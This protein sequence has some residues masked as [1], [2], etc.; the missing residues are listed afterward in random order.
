MKVIKRDGTIV[1]YD[2][3]KIFI[4]IGKANDEVLDEEKATEEEIKEIVKYIESLNKKRILVEDIQDLIELKLMEM[5]RYELAKHYIVYRY[6]RALVRKSNTTDESIIRL[7]RNNQ[8]DLNDNNSRIASVQ[9][10]YIAGEVST[11]LTKRVLLRSKIV[12]AHESGMIHF[13]NMD[14]F[15]HPI[16]DKSFI[17]IEDM[18]NNGTFING[19]FIDQPK[20]FR[21]ACIVICQIIQA[22]LQNQCG[23]VTIDLGVLGKYYRMSYNSISQSIKLCL[24]DISDY[25]LNHVVFREAERELHAGL[26]TLVYQL[27]TMVTHS[28]EKPDVTFVM[29]LDENDPYIN[30]NNYIFS[31]MIRY[32]REGIKNKD[33]N[34][35]ETEIPKL[36]YGINENNYKRGT[37]YFSTT[38]QA[39]DCILY[40][41]Y[42][43]ELFSVKVGHE[44]VDNEISNSKRSEKK[45]NGVF[46]IGVVTI[47]LPQ[48]GIIADGDLNQFWKLFDERLD[49]VREALMLRYHALLSGTSDTA[50]II[51]QN[52][53]IARLNNGEKID[54]YVKESSL[55]LG[56]IGL[57]ELT[58]L[59]TGV[60]LSNEKGKEFGEKVLKYMNNKCNEWTKETGLSF[61]VY[62]TPDK[63]IY[64]RFAKIDL[65]HYGNIKDVTDKGYYTNS[66]HIDYRE[67]IDKLDRLKIESEFQKLSSGDS[68]IYFN[69]GSYNEEEVDKLIEYI[70]DNVLSVKIKRVF[71]EGK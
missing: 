2:K 16:F 61:N 10:N 65:E 34:W 59:M 43:L 41:K 9:R 12:E 29:Y 60:S 4:A 19:I 49:I 52:G 11:D 54:E 55:S 53:A 26:Q 63:E 47:N 38:E 40:S 24:K 13:H 42:G 58:K 17:D 57:Y 62:G 56:Y 25:D 67:N 6:R 37:K 8:I 44:I 3:E 33:G 32:K 46:S 22:V 5:K 27:N 15:I 69:V 31:E 30:D 7:I 48:I 64:K 68:D 66:Y 45:G 50:P 35:V 1:D 18:L 20:S 70:Y 36:L 23:G 14:Y 51:W 71:D 39:R 28:G 21:V